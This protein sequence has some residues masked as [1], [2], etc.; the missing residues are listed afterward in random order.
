MTLPFFDLLLHDSLAFA[1]SFFQFSPVNNFRVAKAMGND[2]SFLQ[3]FRRHSHTGTPV[4]SICA[5][6]FCVNGSWLDSTRP[7]H[8]SG[9]RASRS[10]TSGSRFDCRSREQIR[11]LR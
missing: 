7:A 6:N 8:I 11:I 2:S 10:C 3:N 4:P 9:H 5:R 1:G